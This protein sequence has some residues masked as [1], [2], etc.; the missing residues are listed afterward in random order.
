[1]GTIHEKAAL[2]F[3]WR[4]GERDVLVPFLA[5][6]DVT[7]AERKTYRGSELS[8]MFLQPERTIQDQ[9]GI[10]SE[11]LLVISDYNSV[12][13]R[14]MQAI[15]EALQDTPA[16]GRVDQTTFF[17]VTKN[18]GSKEWVENYSALN[19][20]S[21]VPIVL[22]L[23]EV[24]SGRADP[25]FI[26][27]Q[28]S[29]QLYSRDLFNEQLPLINDLFFFG[30]DQIVAEFLNS[31]KLSQNRGLFGLRKTGKTSILFKLRRIDEQVRG[32]LAK[33]L[34]GKSVASLADPY[35]TLQQAV[36]DGLF[37][38]FQLEIERFA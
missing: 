15:E 33:D 20:Q 31:S 35:F 4:V 37:V 9:F 5:N 30:R 3:R 24:L 18:E 22:T 28:M 10:T 29:D 13:P 32:L 8:F 7:Y 1:M 38:G 26:R 21:R 16:K 23:K 34:R 2:H 11:V 25:W 36:L 27:Q 6:F 19:P 14:T 17:F 12:Q